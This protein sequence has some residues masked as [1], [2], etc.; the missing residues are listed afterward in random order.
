MLPSNMYR[1]SAGALIVAGVCL[2]IKKTIVELLLPL[3]VA[4]NS[5]GTVVPLLGLFGITAIYFY[6]REASGRLGGIGYLVNL[7]GL[8]LACGG[9]YSKNYI[10]A[11]L[12]PSTPQALLA[13]PTRL[14]LLTS[15]PIFL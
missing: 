12:D 6:Q 15:G 9:E 14:V 8:G 1:L 4:T 10:F 7:L 13:G 3:N 5:V 2:I 11:F